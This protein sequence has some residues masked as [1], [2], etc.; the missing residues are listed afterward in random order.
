MTGEQKTKGPVMPKARVK[1]SYRLPKKYKL[2]K[3]IDHKKT[4]KRIPTT[5]WGFKAM[6][7]ANTLEEIRQKIVEKIERDRLKREKSG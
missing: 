6:Y 2:I 1:T 4:V 3:R 7:Q 5:D